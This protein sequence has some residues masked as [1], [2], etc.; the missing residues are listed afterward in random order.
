MNH[1]GTASL[2]WALQARTKRESGADIPFQFS[3]FGADLRD[4][5]IQGGITGILF[6]ATTAGGNQP[7]LGFERQPQRRLSFPAQTSK[8]SRIRWLSRQGPSRE[9]ARRE[10]R[11]LYNRS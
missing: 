4:S 8:S 6:L 5:G 11:A 3:I 2:G 9:N 7:R 10:Y 1:T